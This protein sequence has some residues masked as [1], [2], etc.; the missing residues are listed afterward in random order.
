MLVVE[1]ESLVAVES[2]WAVVPGKVM[3]A[4]LLQ[5]VNVDSTKITPAAHRI[6]DLLFMGIGFKYLIHWQV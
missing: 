6:G 1:E 5:A 3:D 2:L 4:F